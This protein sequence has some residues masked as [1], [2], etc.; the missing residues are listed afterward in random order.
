LILSKIFFSHDLI[1][2]ILQLPCLQIWI[3]FTQEYAMAF[4]MKAITESTQFC[5]SMYG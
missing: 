3:L 1:H 5:L 2:C 4:W